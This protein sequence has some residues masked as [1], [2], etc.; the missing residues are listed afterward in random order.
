MPGA[1]ATLD[2]LVGAA[3][4]EVGR[5]TPPVSPTAGDCYVLGDS[6]VGVWAGHARALAGFTDGGWRF[7]EAF[8][9]MTVLDRSQN[10]V[11]KFDGAAWSIG[12][13]SGKT[14]KLD[15]VQVVGAQQPAI[16]NHAS[17]G[18]I[19]SILAALRAHGL[20]AG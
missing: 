16:S 10:C 14:L 7:A 2:L 13:V 4:L 19:N 20:I 6:P 1:L 8:A 12:E 17:D 9:G 18:T 15:G 5:N 3:V 11:G